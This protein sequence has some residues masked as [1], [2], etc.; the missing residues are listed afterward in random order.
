MKPEKALLNS[1]DNSF[2]IWHIIY[3]IYTRSESLHVDTFI[4][5]G[6]LSIIC[7]VPIGNSCMSISEKKSFPSVQRSAAGIR[8]HATSPLQRNFLIRY[9]RDGNQ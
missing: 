2:Q 5:I 8:T 3:D 4:T 6:R 1:L 9:S 7:V